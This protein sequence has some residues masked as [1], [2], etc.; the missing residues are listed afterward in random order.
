MSIRPL[1]RFQIGEA[2]GWFEECVEGDPTLATNLV[3][4]MKPV[5]ARNSPMP[6]EEVDAIGPYA[7]AQTEAADDR[8]AGWTITITPAQSA[9]IPAGLYL[10]DVGFT[11]GGLVRCT[12][13]VC[14][15]FVHSA[16]LS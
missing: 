12:E 11:F 2:A 14:L 13:P 9:L 8:L 10:A 6:G 7:V 3:A 4:K 5:R 15:E 1:Y 16:A